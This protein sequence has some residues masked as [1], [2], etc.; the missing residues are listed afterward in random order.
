[1]ERG[2]ILDKLELNLDS[3]FEGCY[4]YTDYDIGGYGDRII[5]NSDEKEVFLD[6]FAKEWRK[7]AESLLVHFDW[8]DVRP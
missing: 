1:M 5:I 6:A 4:Y 8:D 2:E 3:L 7:R